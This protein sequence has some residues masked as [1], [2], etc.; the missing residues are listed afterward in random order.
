MKIQL[1]RYYALILFQLLGLSPIAAQTQ[2]PFDS[3]RWY[4]QEYPK[5]PGITSHEMEKYLGKSGILLRNTDAQLKDASFTN[6]IIEYDLAFGPE[7]KGIGISFRMTDAANCESFFIRPHQ[8]GN[9]D[10]TQYM[11]LYQNMDSWQLYYGQ[12]YSA[13]VSFTF[14]QWVHFKLVVSGQQMEVFIGDMEKPVLF[15]QEL[16]RPVNGGMISLFGNGARFANFSYTHLPNPT[17]KSIPLSIVPVSKGTITQWQVSQTFPEKKLDKLLKLTPSQMI[18]LS[19]QSMTTEKSGLLNLAT[20]PTWS[21]ENNTTFAR[22]IIESDQAQIKPLRLGFSD[23]AKVYLNEQL[24]YSG[25]DEFQSRDY[26]FMGT[27]GYYDELY[28][29]L[30][31]GRNELWVA[32]SENFGGWGIKAVIDDQSG[33]KINLD[34][35]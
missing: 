28:L 27:I 21:K 17:I 30:K 15:V 8:S 1:F 34:F 22:L 35:K 31:K 16:K 20:G 6:G 11:P 32:V 23:R 9:A 33:M 13:P 25:Q 29:P 26:R 7:R 19:W 10:A 14:N 3:D 4:F 18:G 5:R 24:L 12:G 2:V